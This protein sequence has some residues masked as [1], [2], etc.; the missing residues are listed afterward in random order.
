MAGRWRCL[1]KRLDVKLNNVPHIVAACIV[2]HNLCETAGDVF[3]AEWTQDI[4]SD[5]PNVVT[6]ATSTGRQ[7]GAPIRN[8]IARYFSTTSTRS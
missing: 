4:P 1:L 7:A 6:T 5:P 2:L 3:L 8:A